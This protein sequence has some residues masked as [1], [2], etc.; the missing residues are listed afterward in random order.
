MW[1][2]VSTLALAAIAIIALIL[3]PKWA[4]AAGREFQA[5]RIISCDKA[6]QSAQVAEHAKSIAIS[7]TE[8]V[9]DVNGSMDAVLDVNLAAGSQ[10]CEALNIV[11]LAG[12]VVGTVRSDA[13]VYQVLKVMVVGMEEEDGIAPLVEPIFRF[14]I[15]RVDERRS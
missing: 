13:G 6:E 8:V 11:Y 3:L 12:D 1:R 7:A 2:I 14:M 9:V 4:L 15:R 5:E 10:V